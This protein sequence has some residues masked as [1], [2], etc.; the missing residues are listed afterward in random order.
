MF[1][2]LHLFCPYE[3]N[4]AANHNTMHPMS[5]AV[6]LLL[7][8]LKC[9]FKSV[10]LSVHF[11]A[12]SCTLAISTRK[13]LCLLSLHTRHPLAFHCMLTANFSFALLSFILIS[14]VCSPLWLSLAVLHPAHLLKVDPV[15]IL[16]QH[17]RNSIKS[18]VI[19]PAFLPGACSGRTQL[20]TGSSVQIY[21]I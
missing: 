16:L 21:N 9:N 15:W 17:G 2:F 1:M 20:V 18:A 4:A 6:F 14:L 10:F 8:P 3:I 19:L 13:R 7:F 12:L 11:P 5:S